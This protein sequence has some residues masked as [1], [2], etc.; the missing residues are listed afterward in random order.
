MAGVE[1]GRPGADRAGSLRRNADFLNLWAGQTA[2]LFGSQITTLALPLLAA[3]TLGA[4]P[5]QMSLLT[6]AG[7]APDLLVGLVAGVWVDRLRRRPLLIA[8]DLGRAALLLVIPLAALAGALSIGLLV[9]IAFGLGLL[10]TLFGIAYSSYLPALVPRD[11]LAEANGRLDTSSA[12]AGVAGPGLAG[13][14]VQVVTAPVAVALDA[15]SFLVSALL[16]GRIRAVEAPPRAEARR[17]LWRE[18]GE[19]LRAVAGSPLLRALAGTTM[20]FNFFDSFLIAIY[21]LYL[22]REL[23]LGAAAVGAVFAIGGAGGVLGAALAGRIARWAG[24][25]RALIGAV[26]LAAIGELGIAL[27]GGPPL[28]ALALVGVAE[29]TVQG[30]AFSF[31]VNSVSLRQAATPDRLLGRVTAT[32]RFMRT[33]LVPLGALLG[34]LVAERYGL[35]PSVLVAGLGTLLAVLWVLFSPIR[36][37]R[38]APPPVEE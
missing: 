37:L 21:V 33:G 14:L 5:A 31:G 6:A 16:L 24:L 25:G 4:T 8:A 19:G 35:R 3:L 9:A 26:L 13:G 1:V 38:T 28:V 17:G 32:M 22:T 34:G 18:V 10:T 12:V 27:A 29:A 20:T 11:E 7:T 2:S 30:A 36:A 23:G 15:V